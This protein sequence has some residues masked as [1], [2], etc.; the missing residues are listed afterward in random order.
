MC[1][2][3]NRVR[4]HRPRL[5]RYHHSASFLGQPL[6]PYDQYLR[7]KLVHTASGSFMCT[8]C[9]NQ[10]KYRDILD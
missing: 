4:P 8:L 7:E 3:F 2:E 10:Q 5:R 6:L 1:W 9:G